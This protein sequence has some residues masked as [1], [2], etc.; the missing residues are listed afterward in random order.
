[1]TL[2]YWAY[3]SLPKAL[4]GEY[5]FQLC[6]YEKEVQECRIPQLSLPFSSASAPIVTHQQ[7]KLKFKENNEKLVSHGVTGIQ[8]FEN[9]PTYRRT[10][11]ILTMC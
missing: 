5:T 6:E 1:M 11:A 7:G 9:V 8:S 2:L 10:D 3:A 4:L